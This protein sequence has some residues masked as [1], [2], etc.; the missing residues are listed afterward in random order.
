[1]NLI[2]IKP[3]DDIQSIF[4]VYRFGQDKPCYIYRLL[5]QGT[6]EEKIYNRQV[7]K[8]S[9]A[10]RVVDEQQ[11]DRHFTQSELKELYNFQPDIWD[12]SRKHD[13]PVL[14]NDSILAE[15][16]KSCEKW[17]SRYHEHDTLLQN[18]ED[19]G[20]SEAER[21]AAWKE[22]EAEKQ[23]RLKSHPMSQ[24]STSQSDERNIMPDLS[25]IHDWI[26]PGLNHIQQLQYIELYE[27]EKLRQQIE[28]QIMIEQYRL[29][30]QIQGNHNLQKNHKNNQILNSLLN[31]KK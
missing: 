8:Q 28:Y 18:R 15:L 22:Y 11:L 3:S 21:Q 12:E 9:L 24:P 27:Q 1:M 2:Y 13:T 10:M 6:M 14:P 30:Q 31:G 7:T 19:E 17:I 26:P 16:L 25:A 23:G 5:S 29:Q 4:R 20:L